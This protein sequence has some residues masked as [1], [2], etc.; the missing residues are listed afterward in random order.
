MPA[1]T[2]GTSSTWKLTA[3]SPT[4]N[5]VGTTSCFTGKLPAGQRA[6]SPRNTLLPHEKKYPRPNPALLTNVPEELR[7]TPQWDCWKYIKGAKVPINPLTGRVYKRDDGETT[8]SDDMG[9]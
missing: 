2:A 6:A 1:A 9:V 5:S 4:S 8:P 7:K 3:P